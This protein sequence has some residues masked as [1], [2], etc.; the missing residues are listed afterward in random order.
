MIRKSHFSK[1]LT[2]PLG[3]TEVETHRSDQGY[4]GPIK[5][6]LGRNKLEELF[7]L[8]IDDLEPQL[9]HHERREGDKGET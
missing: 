7:F 8:K 2:Q 4:L 3:R 6:V 1:V 5:T 9:R